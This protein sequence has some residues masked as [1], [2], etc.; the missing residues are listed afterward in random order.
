MHGDIT[1]LGQLSDDV[2]TER[3]NVPLEKFNK[4]HHG[5]PTTD[6]DFFFLW[7]RLIA[8]KLEKRMLAQLFQV[9]IHF[10]LCHLFQQTTGNTFNA[11]II[12]VS[13]IK[14]R[15]DHYLWNSVDPKTRFSFVKKKKDSKWRDNIAPT[16]LLIC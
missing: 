12:I 1:F 4:F 15:L 16:S 10:H 9:P 14:T 7:F 3:Q 2:I 6:G 11:Q 8:L 5:A 13:L